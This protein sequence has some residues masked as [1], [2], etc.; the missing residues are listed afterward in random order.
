MSGLTSVNIP[1]SVTSIGHQAYYAC[2]GLTSVNIP[3]SV[4]SIGRAAF[5]ESSNLT[6]VTIG[7]GITSIGDQAFYDC[8]SLKEVTCLATIAPELGNLV[9]T[10]SYVWGGVIRVPIGSDYSSWTSKLRSNWTIE[11]I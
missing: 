8:G 9:F 5:M 7:N 2:D 11:Y 4:T 6:S 10:K 1:D 3:D